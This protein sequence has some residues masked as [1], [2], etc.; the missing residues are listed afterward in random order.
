[1]EHPSTV[2]DLHLGVS[3]QID[4]LLLSDYI[5]EAIVH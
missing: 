3:V 1:M 4:F 2:D 5:P